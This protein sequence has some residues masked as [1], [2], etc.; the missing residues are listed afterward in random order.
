MYKRQVQKLTS[1]KGEFSSENSY[2]LYM[3][4]RELESMLVSIN[5]NGDYCRDVFV[6][7]QNNGKVVSSYGCMNFDLYCELYCGDQADMKENL[8]QELTEYHFQDIVRMDSSWG[9]EDP[10]VLMTMTNLQGEYGNTSATVS[11][12]HLDVYKRQAFHSS[13]GPRG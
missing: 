5:K 2:D 4:T 12:T 9:G 3:L 7:F 8:R 6:Y 10:M 1:V 11:Y 13:A